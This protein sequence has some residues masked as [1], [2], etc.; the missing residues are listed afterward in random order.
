MAARNAQPSNGEITALRNYLTSLGL[1][2]TKWNQV[3]PTTPQ[4][5]EEAERTLAAW[6]KVQLRA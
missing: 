3:F 1:T 4:T 5:W 6:I 2:V